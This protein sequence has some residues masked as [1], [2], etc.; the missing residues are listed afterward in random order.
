MTANSALRA[1]SPARLGLAGV[2]AAS[3][4]AAFGGGFGG[5]GIFAATCAGSST[6]DARSSFSFCSTAALGATAYNSCARPCL[7]SGAPTCLNSS[8]YAES[9]LPTAS[10]KAREAVICPG[11]AKSMMRL[12]ALMPSPTKLGRA[13]RSV[14][15]LTDPK[16]KAGAQAIRR[17]TRRTR[18]LPEILRNRQRHV[19][20]VL[21]TGGK[22]DQCPVAG[23][24][25]PIVDVEK[26][27]KIPAQN[28]RQRGLGSVLL[29][30]RSLR[31]SDQVGEEEARDKR[32]AR[33]VPLGF[34]HGEFTNGSLAPAISLRREIV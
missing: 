9:R 18:G 33:R 8:A 12:A 28:R 14:D 2:S 31:V 30:R 27:C 22:R 15:S 13:S 4:L 6:A 3:A 16:M 25:D 1:I 26:G 10:K 24:L 32:A 29:G 11:S 5:A 21:G 17:K 20:R 19:E 23:V 34:G 7:S